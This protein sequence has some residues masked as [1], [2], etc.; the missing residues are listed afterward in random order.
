MIN[1]VKDTKIDRVSNGAAA[2]TTN[3]TSDVVD[4][5]EFDSCMFIAE[6][7]DVTDTS[8]LTLKIQQG[9]ESD[10][11]DMSDLANPSA[12]FTAGAS[13][14]DDKAIATLSDQPTGRVRCSRE[15][16]ESTPK[17]R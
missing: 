17:H 7:G 2:G 10:G 15:K 3:I 5:K 8:E 12:S 16:S 14:A 6:L 4:M 11:S 1:L 13:D 9:D